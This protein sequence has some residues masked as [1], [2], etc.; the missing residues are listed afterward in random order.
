MKTS[1]Q[2]LFIT[3]YTFHEDIAAGCHFALNDESAFVDSIIRRFAKVD[4]FFSIQ[5]R[6]MEFLHEH[7][8]T[9]GEFR[10]LIGEGDYT[11]FVHHYLVAFTSIADETK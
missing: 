11:I 5:E 6:I 10:F 4:N 8:Y 2:G 1:A 9:N 7:R 3:H